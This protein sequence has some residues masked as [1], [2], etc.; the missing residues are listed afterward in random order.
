M[1]WDQMRWKDNLITFHTVHSMHHEILQNDTILHR[2]LDIRLTV[3][4]LTSLHQNHSA[5]KLEDL[6]HSAL[7][8]IR[9]SLQDLF[10]VYSWTNIAS[11]SQKI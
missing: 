11:R 5:A 7:G 9:S 8:R 3:D 1:M 6:N 2:N 10:N 4:L